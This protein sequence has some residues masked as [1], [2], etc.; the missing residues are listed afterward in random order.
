V[1]EGAT[2][3]PSH[4][5]SPDRKLSSAICKKFQPIKLTELYFLCFRGLSDSLGYLSNFKELFKL[6][7]LQLTSSYTPLRLFSFFPAT[8]FSTFYRT[9][10]FT[11]ATI[12]IF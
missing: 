10:A 8:N 12:I 4:G 6:P 11:I 9:R 7:H 2:I 1:G 3:V 5:W